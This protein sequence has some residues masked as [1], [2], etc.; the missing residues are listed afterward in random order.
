LKNP[1]EESFFKL[2]EKFKLTKYESVKQQK[3][4][5]YRKDKNK[6]GNRC[7]QWLVPIRKPIGK[8]RPLDQQHRGSGAGKNN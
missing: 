3:H 7:P 4:I 6:I 5:V 8:Q 1:F 2:P